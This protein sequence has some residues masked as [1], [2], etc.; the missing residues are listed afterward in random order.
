MSLSRSSRTSLLLVLPIAVASLQG[1]S[2]DDTNPA[3]PASPV[4]G[5][6]VDATVGGDAGGKDASSVD[7]GAPNDAGALAKIN[8]VIVIY[9]E[10]H[11]F[12]NLYGEFPGAD[13]LADGGSYVPQID[14]STG[15][16]FTTLPMATLSDGGLVDPRLPTNLPN[17]PYAIEDYI[18][19]DATPPDLLHIFYLEQIEINGG[20]MDLFA[21]DSNAKGETVGHYHTMNLPVPNVA[22][23]YT[24]CDRFF[25]AAFG[26][27][28]L[29]HQWLIAAQSPA[30][31]IDQAA[32]AGILNAPDA[33]ALPA[34][35][36][37]AVTADGYG[38]NTLYSVNPPHPYYG[39]S[40]QKRVPLL[41]NDTIGDRLTAAGL[42][43]AWY[44]GGWNDAVYFD[45]SDG[46]VLDGGVS[47]AVEDFQYHHQPFNYFAKYAPGQPGR[48]HL[49]DEA[50][51]DAALAAHA[52]P[53]VSFIKPVGID[54]EHPGYTDVL[55]GDQHLLG[56]IQ[57]I[58]S[59]PYFTQ[60]KDVAIV[61]TYDEHGGFAD[62]VA[63]PVVDRWGPGGRVPTIVISPWAKKAFVDHSTYDTTSILAF[64]EKRWNLAP[65]GA[66]DMNASPLTGAFDFTQTP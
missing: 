21:G 18:P 40:P 8:H 46:G 26:G 33:T 5:G 3:A 32:D 36:E 64:I 13:G 45:E 23:G 24:V 30:F 37:K 34:G 50:D 17:A 14:P 10:N 49:K 16:P 62:H 47:P 63:P 60:S 19:A 1:C 58:T 4:D 2:G 31:P 29:N 51:F 53:A 35:V 41:T 11:S 56:L 38:V 7:T 43:W 22:T 59:S 57:S 65:L 9:M 27:S 44:S 42:D 25:H 61:I 12:D 39:D 15:L 20:K 6:S 52:L 28:F 54:N 48:A 66:R 55:S